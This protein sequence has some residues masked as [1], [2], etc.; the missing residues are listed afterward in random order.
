MTKVPNHKYTVTEIDTILIIFIIHKL[1][2]IPEWV[3]IAVTTLKQLINHILP[4]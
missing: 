2:E 4:I 1:I 3:S